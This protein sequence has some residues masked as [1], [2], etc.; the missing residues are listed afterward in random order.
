MGLDLWTA[1]FIDRQQPAVPA[2]YGPIGGDDI[3]ASVGAM[4]VSMKRGSYVSSATLIFVTDRYPCRST[5]CCVFCVWLAALYRRCTANKTT[6][7][8]AP[9]CTTERPEFQN[10][11]RGASPQT[12]LHA[13]RGMPIHVTYLFNILCTGLANTKPDNACLC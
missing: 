2:A 13:L 1:G 8:N 6:S 10:F 12:P 4:T 5:E 9:K 7:Q 11:P 3:A